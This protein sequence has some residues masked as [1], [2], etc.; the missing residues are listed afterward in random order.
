MFRAINKAGR[1]G[2]TARRPRCSRMS[3]APQRLARAS[4]SLPHTTYGAPAL[5][6]AILPAASWISFS[7]RDPID[8]CIVVASAGCP[9][10]HGGSMPGHFHEGDNMPTIVGY[11]DIAKGQDHW[12]R[13]PKRK[14]LFGPLASPISGRSWIRRT[15]SEW[16][17]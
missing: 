16:L 9:T 8:F 12:L 4:T 6:F 17:W 11:H 3:S 1:V 5:V 15:R 2:Q 7:C 10:H 14:E 13:S